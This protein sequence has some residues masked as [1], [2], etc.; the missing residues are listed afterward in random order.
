MSLFSFNQGNVSISS[1]FM[2]HFSQ[3]I[4]QFISSSLAVMFVSISQGV[5]FQ[6][7]SWV[8]A[9]ILISLSKRKTIQSFVTSLEFFIRY[10][11]LSVQFWIFTFQVALT[12]S[13]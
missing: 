2:F 5:I 9:G 6:S 3:I 11:S 12:L 7:E 8:Q 4:F 13:F 1:D 10:I